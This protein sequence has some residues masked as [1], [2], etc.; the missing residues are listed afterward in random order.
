VVLAP[1]V[2][3]GLYEVTTQIGA[4]GMGEVYRARDTKLG[5]E[6]ALKVLPSSF[7][8]D[9]ERVARFEREAKTLAALNHPNIGGIHGIQEANG[10]TALVLELVEGPTLADRIAQGAIPL[11]EVLPIAKQIAE[12]LEA[13]HEQGIVHRDL[14]PANVKVRPDGTVKV[15]DFGLAK[16]VEDPA[17]LREATAS[18]TIT[19]PA[20][21]TGAGVILGTAP[22][23]SPEQ[24]KGRP[25]DK[26]S[27]VW[28]FGC[29]LYEMLTGRRAF[30]GDDVSDTLAG[31]LRGEPDWRTLPAD[32]PGSI[33]RL[34]RRAL[35]KDRKRRLS[36]IA[37]ARLDIEEALTTPASDTSA[38][39]VTGSHGGWRRGAVVAAAAFAVGG[40]A[41]A[42]AM[43]I[44]IRPGPARVTRTIIQTSG[45]TALA[46]GA[47]S[48]AITPDGSRLVYTAAGQVVVRR[49]DQF[50]PEPLTGPGTPAQPFISP[51]GQ[52]VGYFDGFVIKKVAIDGGPAVTVFQDS[53]PSGG[54][55]GGTWGVDGTIV[56]GGAIGGGL[57]RVPAAGG[58]EAKTLTTL[59]RARGEVRHAWPAFLPGG[60]ALLFTIYYADGG[61]DSARIAVLDLTTGA[62]SEL[63]SGAHARYLRSGHLVFAAEATLRAVAFDLERRTVV[64]APVPVVAPVYGFDV[65]TDGT[66]VY[67]ATSTG[68]PP[69]RTLVWVDRQG[70]ETP[71]GMQ[72]GPHIHPRLAPDGTR[73]AITKGRNVWLWDLARARLT[74]VTLDMGTI[75]QWTPD[76]ARLVYSSP[77]GG[78][79]ANLYEQAADGTGAAARLTDSP[80]VHHPT[81]ITSD[82]TQIVFNEATPNRLGDI[83]LLTMNTRQVTPLVATRFDERGGVVSPDGRWL[84]YESNRSGAYE[85]WVQPF[86]VVDAG[87]WQVSTAGG[88]QPLWARSGREL[89]YVAPDGALMTVQWEARGSIW[90]AG[91]Q[92]RILEG[93]YFR[94]SEG[95]TVR[96]YDVTADGQRFLMIKDESRSTNA[97]PAISVVLN[98]TE[99][100][101]RLV[102]AR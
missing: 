36:D 9:P 100:L 44:A 49:L 67:L 16:A 71:L 78:G 88:R 76:S 51:D 62:T 41:A 58:G 55:L 12:A 98:W 92:T 15:L 91:A 42:T 37:D 30:P 38:A 87:L 2:R 40:A 59:D 93:R 5:R 24:A 68:A 70:R 13:A 72:A 45:A 65:A 54:P 31:V 77:R 94:A 81:G 101:K 7:V 3:F 74:P 29:V 73:V 79:G 83:G 84:A 46:T 86:P 61:P 4:G 6:V 90:S 8:T 69:T 52:W 35:Q 75:T 43:W 85:V 89:F 102:P 20:M 22:Y 18:P 99:E 80:N 11:D 63:L 17:S 21:M 33:R 96:Q 95:T 25:A 48:L 14:K 34:L 60:R 1:G 64:G 10:A 23:M 19:S 39:P 50:D 66:L 53:N 27:D 32:T 56:F 28:A 26:R 97:A 82:G 57:K 47:G